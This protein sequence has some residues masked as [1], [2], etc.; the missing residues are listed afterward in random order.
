MTSGSKPRL[1]TAFAPAEVGKAVASTQGNASLLNDDSRHRS[2]LGAHSSGDRRDGGRKQV[3]GD[4]GRGGC[5]RGGA[6]GQGRGAAA[7][8]DSGERSVAAA[9]EQGAQDRQEGGL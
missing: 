5:G 7:L 6:R 2:R 4:G 8:G 3:G 1:R 9:R